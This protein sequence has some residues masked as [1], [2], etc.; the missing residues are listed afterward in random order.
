M[1][2]VDQE[3]LSVLYCCNFPLSMQKNHMKQLPLDFKSLHICAN[4]PDPSVLFVSLKVLYRWGP[5]LEVLQLYWTALLLRWPRIWA[6]H[7]FHDNQRVG[8][9]ARGGRPAHV[10]DGHHW[11][12]EP[13][14]ERVWVNLTTYY[15][16]LLVSHALISHIRLACQVWLSYK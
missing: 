11:F 7:Q 3:E 2:N 9:P 14:N 6:W 13:H 16:W 4:L 10:G 15:P 8:F 5:V 1:P 12:P